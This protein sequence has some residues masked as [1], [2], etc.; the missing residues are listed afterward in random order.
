MEPYKHNLIEMLFSSAITSMRDADKNLRNLLKTTA[1]PDHVH[2]LSHFISQVKALLVQME[3]QQQIWMHALSDPAPRVQKLPNKPLHPV[4]ISNVTKKYDISR[5]PA[6]LTY[7]N[8]RLSQTDPNV[9]RMMNFIG[10]E[11]KKIKNSQH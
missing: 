7:T 11:Y 3:S 10:S 2:T 9:Q 6:G 8:L 5:R 4:N 1:R